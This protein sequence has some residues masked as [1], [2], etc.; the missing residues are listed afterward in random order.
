[1]LTIDRKSLVESLNSKLY[2]LYKYQHQKKWLE[3]DIKVEV[4]F[5]KMFAGVE[6]PMVKEADIESKHKKKI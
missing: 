4:V 3:E 6:I 5:V 1:M 2:V